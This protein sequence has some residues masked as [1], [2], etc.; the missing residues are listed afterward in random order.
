M[1]KDVIYIDVEDDI[2][3]IIGKVKGANQKI[4]AL[5]PPKRIGVLQSAVNLRLLARAATNSDKRLVLISNNPSLM[6]LAA[7]AKV[8]VAK[9]LQSKPELASIPVLEIDDGEDVIDGAQLPIGDHART[10]PNA[11]SNVVNPAMDAAIGEIAIEETTGR[12]VAPTPG[13]SLVSPK[14]KSG[15]KVPNFNSFRK[16]LVL[17][18]AAI[19][20]LVGLLI[21]AIFFAPHATVLITA[22]TN[23]ASVNNKVTFDSATNTNLETNTIRSSSQEIKKD[24]SIEF[25]ATGKKNIG[26][27]ATGTM[28]LTRTSVSSNAISVPVGTT[29]TAGS[30]TFVSTQAATLAATSVGPGGLVQDSA[31]IA[32]EASDLG[33]DYNVAA[34]TYSASVGGFNSQGS[35]MAGGTTNEVVVV[36]ADDIQKATDA[37]KQKNNDAIKNELKAQFSGNV[38]I[39]NTTFKTVAGTVVSSPAVDQELAAGAGKPKLTAN[40]TYTISG[41]LKTEISSYLNGYFEKELNSD[42]RIYSNGLDEATFT[43][44]NAPAEGKVTANIVAN[45]KIGP[46]INDDKIKDLAKGKRYGEIQASIEAIPGVDNV[47]V[48][49]S[50]FWVSSAPNDVKKIKVEFKLND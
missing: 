37:L 31:T 30:L 38:V 44:V 21:W 32:V 41:V 33:P 45:A 26:D 17:I 11:A 13:Q 39:L 3:A 22:R 16:K 49:F 24:D 6:A 28:K 4:V 40:L 34:Q 8:P 35:A 19:A 9:N 1:N 48:K 2:T 12:A 10:A 43:N 50:P 15:V 47:D 27:K 46:K 7:A 25:E 14:A 23:D 18:I 29:F 5:V 20:L 42:Q 36:T